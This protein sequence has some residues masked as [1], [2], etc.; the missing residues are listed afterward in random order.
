M[1]TTSAYLSRLLFCRSKSKPI[2][3]KAP[4]QLI[5]KNMHDKHGRSQ[6]LPVFCDLSIC[7]L[8]ADLLIEK[9]KKKKE[10]DTYLYYAYVSKTFKMIM[11]NQEIFLEFYQ[12]F[13]TS[14][15]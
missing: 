5:N 7:V 4:A 8:G 10:K 3:T 11:R 15:N 9:K 14:K 2:L 13:C 12:K 6:L 1:N